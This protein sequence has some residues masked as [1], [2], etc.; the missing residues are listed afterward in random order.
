VE[1]S[2]RWEYDSRVQPTPA[3]APLTP[4]A[5]AAGPAGPPVPLDLPEVSEPPIWRPSHLVP[6]GGLPA[7]PLPDPTTVPTYLDPELEVAVDQWDMH[8]AHVVCSNGWS[9]WVDGRRLVV[10]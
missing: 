1:A 8:W 9:G 7:W 5:P 2:W 4:P 10:R 6:G 3:A